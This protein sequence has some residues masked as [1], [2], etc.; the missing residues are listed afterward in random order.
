M[1]NNSRLV[2]TR[3]HEY[4]RTHLEQFPQIYLL[5]LLPGFYPDDIFYSTVCM[6]V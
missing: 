2:T 3:P 4:G 5:P 1:L 6:L